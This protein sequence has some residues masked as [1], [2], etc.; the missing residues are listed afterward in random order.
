MSIETYVAYHTCQL[1]NGYEYIC[2]NIPFLSRDGPNQ[3]LTRGFYFWTDSAHWAKQW[4]REGNRVIGQFDLSLCFRTEV[5]D[6][7]GNVHHQ[8]QFIAMRDVVLNKLP[9]SERHNITVNQI[10]NFLREDDV[11]FPYLAIKAQDLKATE[12][13]DFIDK[14]QNNPKI[15][16]VNRQQICVFEK[17]R[18]RI[19]LIGFIEPKPFSEKMPARLQR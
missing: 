19:S 16:L 1:K 17:A 2:T 9:E 4:L 14:G 15:S 10:I 7:V 6:L 11:I 12:K 18:E 5:L 13:I 3:W 8:E